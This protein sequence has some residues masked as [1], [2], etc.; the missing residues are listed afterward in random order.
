MAHPNPPFSD[1]RGYEA[2]SYAHPAAFLSLRNRQIPRTPRC[3]PPPAHSVSVAPEQGRGRR[4]QAN[5][6]PNLVRTTSEPNLH[7]LDEPRRNNE[8]RPLSHEGQHARYMHEYGPANQQAQFHNPDSE[9]DRYTTVDEYEEQLDFQP[10]AEHFREQQRIGHLYPVPQYAPPFAR[11]VEAT[12]FA[13]HPTFPQRPSAPGFSDPHQRR[14]EPASPL[15]HSPQT[16][17]QQNFRFSQ[18]QS[19]GPRR[20]PQPSMSRSSQPSFSSQQVQWLLRNQSGSSAPKTRRLP[21]FSGEL[22]EDPERFL[23]ACETAFIESR[24]DA[25]D[26]PWLGAEQLKGAAASYWQ[27]Y[28]VMYPTWRLFCEKILMKFNSKAILAKASVEFY[29]QYQ[30]DQEDPEVFLTRKNQLYRRLFPDDQEFPV[31]LLPLLRE[32]LKAKYQPYL[33]GVNLTSLDHLIEITSLLESK[34]KFSPKYNNP[35]KNP[36]SAKPEQTAMNN[37]LPQCRHCPKKHLHRDCPVLAEKIRTQRLQ[38]K[39]A[40]SFLQTEECD[41][42]VVIMDAVDTTDSD[43]DEMPTLQQI[44][45]GPELP[46]I[47][48]KL[49]GQ[50]AIAA[51]DSCASV[52]FAEKT[53]VPHN[54]VIKPAPNIAKARLGD[55]QSSLEILG[56]ADLQIEI[57]KWGGNATFFIVASLAEKV[58]LGYQFLKEQEGVLDFNRQCI[59][60]GIRARQTA[61]WLTTPAMHLPAPLDMPVKEWNTDLPLESDNKLKNLVKKNADL[62]I[63]EKTLPRT[64]ALYCDLEVTTNKPIVAGPYKY[65]DARNK[66]IDEEAAK[67]RG[68]DVIEPTTSPH[69]S[70]IVVVIKPEREPRFCIDFRKLNS[71]VEDLHFPMPDTHSAIRRLGEA[72]FFTKLDLKKGYWQIPLTE[73]SKP[74]TAFSVPNGATYQFKVMPFGLK[75]AP[76]IFQQ[77]MTQEVLTGYIGKFVEVYLDDVIIFS[78]TAAE[79]VEHVKRILERLRIFRLV[80]HPEKCV[81]GVKKMPYLGRLLSADGVETQPQSIQAIIQAPAPQTKKQLQSFLGLCGWVREYVPNAAKLLTPLTELLK[82][83]RWRWTPELEESFNKIKLAFGKPRTLSRPDYSKPFILQT[84]ASANGCAAALYQEADTR[85]IISFASAKFSERETKWHSNEQECYAL[86]WAIEKYRPY[87]EGRKFIVRTDNNALVWLNT[88]Q[89][90]KMKFVRWAI[91]LQ[92]YDFTIEHVKGS[93]N[94]LADSLSRY[95]NPQPL[96]V[97]EAPERMFAPTLAIIEIDTHVLEAIKLAQTTDTDLQEIIQAIVELQNQTDADPTN[98]ITSKF[99]FSQ[100]LLFKKFGEEKRVLVPPEAIDDVLQE[101]HDAPYANHPGI[102]ETSY[103]IQKYFWWPTMKSD[104]HDHVVAC[105]ICQKQKFG[106]RCGKAP[107]H[108]RQPQRPFQ[109]ISID[110]MGPYPRS[111]K[112]NTYLLTL[113]D[114]FT[115]WPEAYPLRKATTSNIINKLENEFISRFGVPGAIIADNGPQFRAAF[116]RWCRANGVKIEHTPTYHPRANPVERKNASIKE[117]IKLLL[118]SSDKWDATLPVVLFTLRTR[119]NATTKFS[120]SELLFGVPLLKPK[121]GTLQEICQPEDQGLLLEIRHQA[122]ENQSQVLQKKGKV[123]KKAHPPHLETGDQ[124]LVL[125]HALSNAGQKFHAGF[126]PKWKGPFEIT[127]EESPDVYLVRVETQNVKMHRDQMKMY[128]R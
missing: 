75:N 82:Q 27:P 66:F 39:P 89:G 45:T 84:D 118:S 76:R 90:K 122:Q 127:A 63:Y 81:F 106:G 73:R 6:A 9:E 65:N 24:A 59:M 32:Q 22:I 3:Q 121:E 100:G 62:F 5:A 108:R 92:E 99:E 56:T 60:F 110:L 80:A 87:L 126:Q 113:V 16:S 97:E 74:F 12:Y 7:Q 58:I 103:A 128:R 17:D 111:A 85:R 72:N 78:K 44:K 104:I 102:A 105:D 2:P 57:R 18:P 13:G 112:G 88:A 34:L 40:L 8:H 10:E 51:L 70:P 33:I 125:T 14:Y 119:K 117:G 69:H 95:P 4:P 23:L 115:R 31:N 64:N 35:N 86:V 26:W 48:I 68:L 98:A 55:G 46:R 93:E 41:P 29:S 11:Y 79:H 77:L 36:P 37:E 15:V 30:Q 54:V 114:L 52:C 96:Q 53:L 20:Q 49:E 25:Q 94:Q 28:S 47:P 124:V 1:R 123:E 109:T 71:Y 42:G 83:T 19:R 61:Y 116:D 38:N 21:T 101:F 91:Q 50:G 67:M 43:M 120:P 107:L